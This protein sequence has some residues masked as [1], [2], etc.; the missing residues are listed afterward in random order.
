MALRNFWVEAKIDGRETELEGGPRA[1]DGGMSV[2][3]L[4]RHNGSKMTAVKV[5][6]WE[7]NGDL[8]TR[9]EI[10]GVNVGTFETRR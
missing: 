4:Q 9:V 3:I 8:F 5:N 6:C 7:N 10:G 2:T 1:K